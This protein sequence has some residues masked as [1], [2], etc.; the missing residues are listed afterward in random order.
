MD[1]K[2]Q[3]LAREYFVSRETSK[4]EMICVYP[5]GAFI[6]VVQAP[7]IWQTIFSAVSKFMRFMLRT[8]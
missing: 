1:E 7:I 6:C 8:R 2:C 4:Q 3:Y 5:C